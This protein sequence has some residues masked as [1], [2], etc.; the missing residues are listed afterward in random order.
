[1]HEMDSII[2]I[3]A[4]LGHGSKN[5]IPGYVNSMAIRDSL[6]K[7]HMIGLQR[8]AWISRRRDYE[9]EHFEGTVGCPA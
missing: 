4:D 3:I 6:L 9:R 7:G 5:G 8:G 2:F 1:M